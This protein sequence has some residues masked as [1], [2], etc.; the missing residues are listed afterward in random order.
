MN[1]KTLKEEKIPLLENTLENTLENNIKN[2]FEYTLE[3]NLEYTLE[4]TLKHTLN[5]TLKNNLEN[6]SKNITNNDKCINSNF[7]SQKKFCKCTVFKTKM[8]GGYSWIIT[9]SA[10][11]IHFFVFGFINNVSLLNI[12]WMKEYNIEAG[13]VGIKLF[14]LKFILA[15]VG[16]INVGIL[17][18]FGPF[19]AFLD[20]KL[21]C[22]ATGI[23]GC[24]LSSFG[25]L[26]ASLSSNFMFLLLSYGVLFGLGASCCFFSSIIIQAKYFDKRLA[27]SNGIVTAGSGAGTIFVSSFASNFYS[28]YGWRTGIRYYSFIFL[29]LIIFKMF[30]NDLVVK[31]SICKPSKKNSKKDKIYISP[32]IYMQSFANELLPIYLLKNIPFLIF[33]ISC[34]FFMLGY[35]LPYIHLVIL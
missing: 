23:I 33:N 22:Q 11:F 1:N 3:N 25:V 4:N 6:I 19:A 30:Y 34:I 16:S 28:K 14:L 5:N 12:Y 10:F 8:D 31:M 20:K 26:L 7:E 2:N 13:S 9:F 35:Y 15:W 24:I 27:L 21:G 29:F 18:L 32:L 17:F